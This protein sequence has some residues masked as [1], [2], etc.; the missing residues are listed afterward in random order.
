MK[1]ILISFGILV[2]LSLN[3]YACDGCGCSISQAYFGLSPSN[4]GHY[5]GLWWQHQHYNILPDHLFPERS[6]G[7]D[8]FN[9]LEIRSRFDL[10]SQIQVSAILPYAYHI[11]QRQDETIT[12]NG[13]GDATLLGNITIFDN[14]DSLHLTLRHRLAAGA[15]IKMP[16]GEYRSFEQSNEPNPNFQTGTGSL[17]FLFNLA[18]TLR[19]DKMGM[20][21]EG[22]Y[23]YNGTNEDE[24]R[25]GNRLDI[26]A[27]IY[28]FTQ[29]R[30]VQLMPTL[31]AHY[32]E[33]AWNEENGYFRT[34]TGAKNLL[35]NA[36]LETYWRQFNLGASMSYPLI[37]DWNNEWIEAKERVSV[38]L[39]YFF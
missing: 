23:R 32:E 18:Y 7:Q 13:I 28:H 17:D 6:Y 38:H 12:L 33:A 29:F 4:Q 3:S 39:N 8:Y 9:A 24:Y 30:A 22:T 35:A 14:S 26:A 15:G 1:R 11:R 16:T 34:D 19:L 21:V 2:S 25:F 5:V 36:G 10:S 31:G 37:Q 20:H 27:T